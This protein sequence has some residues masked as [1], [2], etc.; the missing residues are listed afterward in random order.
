MSELN[1]S[2]SKDSKSKK[3]VP[4]RSIFDVLKTANIKMEP[5]EHHQDREHRHQ[6]EKDK[7]LHQQK[8]EWLAW[9]IIFSSIA[10]VALLSFGVIAFKESP[11]AIKGCLALEGSIITAF[12]GYL[13]GRGSK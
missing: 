9:R 3:N 4:E 7:L 10:G 11:D 13:A 12:M 8:L 1:S 5:K 6:V 2:E